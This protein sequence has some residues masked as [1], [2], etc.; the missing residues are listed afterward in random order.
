MWHLSE[1]IPLVLVRIQRNLY[2][3]EH[4]FGTLGHAGGDDRQ[5][6]L[7]W[8]FWGFFVCFVLFSGSG[9]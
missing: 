1:A 4:H 2:L 3:E 9:V 8:F 7:L 6:I 5:L